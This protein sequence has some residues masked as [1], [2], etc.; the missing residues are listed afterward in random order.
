MHIQNVDYQADNAPQDLAQSLRETGFAVLC[1]HPIT[2]AR[3]QAI[4]AS[5]GNFFASEGK[6][7]Y[8]RD[9]IRQDGYFPFKSEHAKDADEKDLKEFFHI[10]PWGRVP[11]NLAAETKAFYA[12]LVG[13]GVELLGWLD[14]Q[15][16]ADISGK[17]SAP[18]REMMTGS[19]QSLLRSL[20]YPPV[21]E[22]ERSAA[23]RA[24]AHEDINL[25]TLLVA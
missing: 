22:H 2:P 21:A 15:L 5:W 23:I 18:L 24:A 19:E 7:D 4:Y 1:N 6:Q 14:G 8:L 9:P 13:L 12:D 16:P 11:E 20:H 25:I 17:L 10:Y 3:I